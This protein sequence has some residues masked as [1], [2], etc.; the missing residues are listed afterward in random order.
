MRKWAFLLVLASCTSFGA[1][2]GPGASADAG[3]AGDAPSD[4]APVDGA[5]LPDGAIVLGDTGTPPATCPEWVT[6]PGRAVTCPGENLP[7][8]LAIDPEN[9]GRCG[10]SCGSGGACEA[11]HC[12]DGDAV[13]G[14]RLLGAGPSGAIVYREGDRVVET[15]LPGGAGQPFSPPIASGASEPMSAIAW[16]DRTYVRT[17][18]SVVPYPP[19]GTTIPYEP[20]PP[21][22]AATDAG[23]FVPGSSGRVLRFPHGTLVGAAQFGVPGITEIAAA[24][25]EPVVIQASAGNAASLAKVSDLGAIVQ[26]VSDAGKARSLVAHGRDAFYVD[27]LALMRV[28][29]DGGAPEVLA[30]VTNDIAAYAGRPAV[31]VTA[32]NVFFVVARGNDNYEVM[33]LE[34]GCASPTPR[35]VAFA[36]NLAGIAAN[37]AHLFYVANTNTVRSQR[38]A[39]KPRS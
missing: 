11:G 39:S 17:G 3:A 5:V 32:T 33:A 35:P 28:S 9:C 10:F 24:E 22:I 12:K 27:G 37:A 38:I 34:R 29:L 13:S 18:D 1:D 14:V 21:T 31:A 6:D 23:L 20:G 30:R 7:R 19:V 26:V 4:G 15:F 2:P 25:A 16:G 8:K 36:Q